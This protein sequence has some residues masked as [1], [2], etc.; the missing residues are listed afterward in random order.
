MAKVSDTKITWHGSAR[1]NKQMTIGLPSGPD[2]DDP[3]L[4]FLESSTSAAVPGGLYIWARSTNVPAYSTTRP[5]NEDTD[6]TDLTAAGANTAL[7]NISS[8]AIP[9]TIASDTANT[10]DLGTDAKPWKTAYLGTSL[11]FDQTTRNLTIT[12]SEPGTS[13][14]TVNFGDPGANDSVA[15]LAANQALTTKT[16]NGMT[17]VAGSNAIALSQGTC[18]ITVAAAGSIDV[19]TAGTFDV[20]TGAVAFN[21]TANFD[22]ATGKTV[23]IDNNVTIQ[24]DLTVSAACTID[25]SLATT[26]APG[27]ATGVT[28]GNLTLANGSITDSS[29]AIDFGNESLTTTGSIN[30]A[31]NSN[32][33]TMG[34]SGAASSCIYFDGATMVLYDT[35]CGPYTLNELA[36][37]TTLN[38]T[39]TG[40][41]TI[42][43]GNF[44]WTNTATSESAIWTLGNTTTA[45][46]KIVADA[47]TSEEI[48]GINADALTSGCFLHLD[49]DQAASFTG[50]FLECISD[51]SNV[52][53]SIKRFGATT[54]AGTAR[55]TAALTLT[56]GDIVV[57]D[58]WLNIDSGNTDGGHNIATSANATNNTAL[59]TITNSDAAYDKELLNIDYNATG[60]FD[61]VV[62]TH[63][64]TGYAIKAT[65]GATGSQG[66]DFIFATGGTGNGIYLDGNTGTYVGSDGAGMLNIQQTGTLAHANATMAF[67][68]F[69]GTY[70]TNGAGAC[71]LI[72]DDG[73]ADGTN[74]AAYINSLGVNCLK[75]TTQA[76][77]GTALY[78]DG[79][80][81]QTAPIINVVGST[82][83]GWDGADGVGMVNLAGVGAHVHANASL[84]HITDATNASIASARGSCL[85]IVDTTTVGADAFVAYISTTA[86]DGLKIDTGHADGINLE[87]QGV[88]AQ[89]APM[90]YLDGTTT[91]GWDGADAVGMIKVEGKG[92]HAHANASLLYI[93]E[94][95]GTTIASARGTCFRV[96]DTTV[97]GADAWVAYIDSTN[98]DGLLINTGA[99]ADVNLKLTGI[100]AQTGQLLHVDGSTGTG[101]VGAATT[102]MLQ[103]DSDGQLAADASCLRIASTGQPAAPNDGFAIDI[104]DTGGAQATSYAVRISSDSNEALHVDAGVSLFDELITATG[105]VSIE[106]STNGVLTLGAGN[107]LTIQNDGTTSKIIVATDALTIGASATNYTGFSTAGVVS[108]A[109]SARPVQYLYFNSDDFTSCGTGTPARGVIPTS[110]AQ[111]WAL[112]GTSSELISTSFR[113]PANWASGTDLT[114]KIY[115]CA[116]DANTLNVKWDVNTMF[117]ADGT[118]NVST[119]SYVS[120]TVTDTMAGAAYVLNVATITIAAVDVVANEYCTLQIERDSTDGADTLNGVDALFLGLEIAYTANAI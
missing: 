102:G 67:L 120:D 52:D 23:N 87:L 93:T 68:N 11:V 17:V 69:D 64:G 119:G 5:T 48:F 43:D 55:G 18:N 88:T 77:T 35:T 84:L 34:T 49:T 54:I 3:G 109:G 14:R 83:A 72:D 73:T 89:A 39:V 7:S 24:G 46:I 76:T 107:E 111:C 45:A 41:L 86:N 117:L 96:V 16:Y 51:G 92:A 81:S 90:L 66:L 112:D 26:D 4:L 22:L 12:A 21:G 79:P 71:L 114:V 50:E 25:Q 99:V 91:D 98:N 38:P 15:Y 100:Q 62:M 36:T 47:M 42:S 82:G 58:G 29:G 78:M 44:T 113:T 27:F 110:L 115:Y 59:I 80:A 94:G 28:I 33:L 31:S 53:F 61:A 118:G 60:A 105:G 6:G 57:T 116:N 37:G 56:A 32:K 104:V 40:N 20:G 85:R 106:D 95:T 8:V 2:G 30:I 19:G 1:N 9:V 63:L 74:Y 103:I 10:D 101:W 13:A 97:N 70:D 75:L 65:G 108:F